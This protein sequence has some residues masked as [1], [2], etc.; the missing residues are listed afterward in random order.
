MPTD[1]KSLREIVLM[2]SPILETDNFDDILQLARALGYSTAE[3]DLRVDRVSDRRG[4]KNLDES[5]TLTALIYLNKDNRPATLILQ[6]PTD[7]KFKMYEYRW[8]P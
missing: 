5:T 1:L 8:I 2:S 3:A 4:Y 7:K 6:D